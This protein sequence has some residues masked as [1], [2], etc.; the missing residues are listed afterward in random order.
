MQARNLTCF[1]IT[2]I[3]VLSISE[4]CF[5]FDDGDFQFWS[6]ASASFDIE[7][8]W[9]ITFEEEFKIGDDAGDLYYHHSDLGLVYKSILGFN[10]RQA[11]QKDSNNKWRR[12]NRPHLNITL[13]GKLSNLDVSSRSRFEYRNRENNKDLWRYRNKVTVKLP[14]ELTSLKLQPYLADEIFINFDEED[15]NKNRLY[16]GLSF[17]LSESI[18]GEVYYLWQS[19]ESDGD[20]KDLNVLGAQLKFY[21]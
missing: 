5:A 7:R 2:V 9:K 12:E 21:F 6:K 19:S 17:K 4:I 13:K 18:K 14:L 15:F 10:Y 16:S 20:W 3:A 1:V 11:F 8:D